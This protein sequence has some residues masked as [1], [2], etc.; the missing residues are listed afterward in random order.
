M[1]APLAA[2]LTAAPGPVGFQELRVPR[3]QSHSRQE[4]RVNPSQV[5][6]LLRRPSPEGRHQLRQSRGLT[7][8]TGGERRRRTQ[9]LVVARGVDDSGP[10]LGQEE[11]AAALVGIDRNERARAGAAAAVIVIEEVLALVVLLDGEE[12]VVQ[13]TS[14][15]VPAEAHR[16]EAAPV[17]APVEAL[18]SYL[19]VPAPAVADRPSSQLES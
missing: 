2:P 14:D 15:A 13:V 9:R 3:V 16:V 10:D 17:K 4:S 12:E 19:V 18:T 7:T 8:V 5:G 11:D 6:V 1:V